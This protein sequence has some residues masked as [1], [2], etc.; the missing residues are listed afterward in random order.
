MRARALRI[1]PAW[2]LCLAVVPVASPAAAQ[3][4]Q[5]PK[6][7]LVDGEVI[8]Y[9]PGR[10]IVIRGADNREVLYN[11]NSG[12]VVPAEYLETVITW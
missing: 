2:W 12:L 5:S 3:S 11:L 6:Y 10:V 1:L 9:D 4:T 7:I 8:R